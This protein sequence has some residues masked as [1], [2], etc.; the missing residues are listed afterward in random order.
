MNEVKPNMISAYC[1]ISESELC[2][3]EPNYN[4]EWFNTDN[5]NHIKLLNTLYDLGINIDEGV[6]VQQS[7]QH[8]NRLNQVVTC[9]RYIGSERIDTSWIESGFASKEAI[10]KASGSKLLEGLYRAKG[11]TIDAQIAM[12]YKDKYSKEGE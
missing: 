6:E 1:I 12:E 7:V 5:P 2:L 8:R 3:A 10:D 4:H 9:G 11:M